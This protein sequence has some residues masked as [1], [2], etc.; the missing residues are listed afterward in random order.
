MFLIAGGRSGRALGSVQ[1][2][3]QAHNDLFDF[4]LG[5][6]LG[7]PGHGSGP[8]DH[9]KRLCRHAEGVRHSHAYPTGAMIE[10]KH[11]P[12]APSRTG[13]RGHGGG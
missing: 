4:I 8:G 11:S 2:C 10:T 13:L 6:Y 9:L 12:G 5:D 3:R 1:G 7:D